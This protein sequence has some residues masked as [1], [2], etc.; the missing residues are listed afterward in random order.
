[1]LS[2]TS[3]QMLRM[4]VL[5]LSPT[6]TLF[7]SQLYFGSIFPQASHPLFNVVC[8]CRA[9]VGLHCSLGH[10]DPL[11]I[12]LF[13]HD[14]I[15]NGLMTLLDRTHCCFHLSLS[16]SPI[17]WASKAESNIPC[18]TRGMSN[19][20][21]KN[22]I[23]SPGPKTTASVICFSRLSWNPSAINEPVMHGEVGAGHLQLP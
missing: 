17:D 21:L 9:L 18:I 10:P 19:L 11:T 3:T 22:K 4:S 20:Q 23:A 1:M 14:D 16:P 8:C 12:V 7:I 5:L 2:S 15:C 6:I 13:F